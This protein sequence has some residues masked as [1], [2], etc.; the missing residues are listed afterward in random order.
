MRKEEKKSLILL[1]VISAAFIILVPFLAIAVYGTVASTAQ[2]AEITEVSVT[3]AGHKEPVQIT[4]FLYDD[5]GGCG[6]GN[7][8]CGPCL[9]LERLNIF[10]RTQFGERLNDGSIE[11]RILNTRISTNNEA[12]AERSVL[13][14]V[15]AELRTTLP[16]AFI[17]NDEYGIFLPGEDL[18]EYVYRMFAKYSDREC[19][20]QLQNEILNM[21]GF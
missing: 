7:L 8:G 6:V 19:L 15:P 17:G 11:Y 9:D 20:T 14:G 2:Y 13:Y 4:V 12:H 3:A 18:M 1:F 16:I 10:I 5:C 21:A